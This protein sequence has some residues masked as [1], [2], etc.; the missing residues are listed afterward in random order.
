MI[1]EM[2]T[3]GLKPR[4]LSDVGKR[5]G[6]A[7]YRLQCQENKILLPSAFSPLQ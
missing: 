7:D 4:S 1:Y 3:Y 5:F 2:R 6:E